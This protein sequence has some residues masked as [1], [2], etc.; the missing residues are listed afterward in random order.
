MFPPVLGE[1]FESKTEWIPQN[2]YLV[3]KIK[4]VNQNQTKQKQKI[5]FSK[6]H[7][8]GIGNFEVR[9]DYFNNSFSLLA[10]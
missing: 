4:A 7:L 3:W 9:H 6:M 1:V 2:Y 5:S 10:I 8:N